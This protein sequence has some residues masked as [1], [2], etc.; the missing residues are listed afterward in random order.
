M[1]KYDKVSPLK[2]FFLDGKI[3][4]YQL[5]LINKL[6]VNNILSKLNILKGEF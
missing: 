6:L 5:T 2:R 3:Q 1:I 4:T